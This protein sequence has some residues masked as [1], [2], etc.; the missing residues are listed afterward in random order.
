MINNSVNGREGSFILTYIV[1]DLEWNMG[2]VRNSFEDLLRARGMAPFNEIVQ[3]G[4]MIC[5]RDFGLQGPFDLQV[6]A[7]VHSKM[8]PYV[9]SVTGLTTAD[10]QRG[11]PFPEAWAQF[12]AWIYDQTGYHLTHEADTPQDPANPPA[13][14]P[15][16]PMD[17][18]PLDSAILFTWGDSDTAVLLEN[19]RYHELSTH[20]NLR[21]IDLQKLYSQLLS[22]PKS[23]RP[24]LTSALTQIGL[25][26]DRRLRAHDAAADAYYTALILRRLVPYIRELLQ[27][28][29]LPLRET[30]AEDIATD[31]TAT[32]NSQGPLEADE[33]QEIYHR[34]LNL[35][36]VPNFSYSKTLRLPFRIRSA[37]LFKHVEQMELHCPGCDR[38]LSVVNP[39]NLAKRLRWTATFHCPTHGDVQANVQVRQVKLRTGPIKRDAQGKEIP[40]EGRPGFN[41]RLNLRLPK[42]F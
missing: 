13:N 2:S 33:A 31:L 19:L 35:G 11:V 34:L 21:V 39:W 16:N 7:E 17:P 30:P 28:Q 5:D 3:I 14:T 37:S 1:L 36:Y 18:A 20:L 22:I 25:E 38:E 26:E 41:G 23:T 9:K 10:L 12:E 24:A 8:N 32:Y 40:Q 42:P 29:Q 4:A 6:R 15:A 27:K